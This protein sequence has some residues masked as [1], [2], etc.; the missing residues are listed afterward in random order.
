MCLVSKEIGSEFSYQENNFGHGILLP[1]G[2][3]DYVY[4]FSGRTAIETVLKNEPQ[5]KKAMLPSYCCDSMIEPFRRKGIKVCFYDVNYKDRLQINIKLEDDIDAILWCNYFGFNV[6][7][8]D[9][10]EFL[11]NGGIIIEDITHSFY[12]SK[13]YDKQSNYLVASIR[14]WEPVLCGGYCASIKTNLKYKP[15]NFPSKEFLEDKKKAMNLKREYLEGNTLIEKREFLEK[16]SKSNKWLADNY[17]ELLMDEE[18]KYI[19]KHID[20]KGNIIQRK[21]NAKELFKGLKKCRCVIPL[22]KEEE[23]DCP[24]FVPILAK[25]ENRSYIRKR[26]TENNIYCPIHWPKPNEKCESNL[27][28]MELSLVCDQRYNENDMKRIIEIIQECE[29]NL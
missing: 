29:K 17:F 25:I 16:F 26:L 7:M 9:F 1:E 18:S 24:L 15:L 3:K 13:K 6:E 23:I 27:Y 19:L 11:I 10:S 12:S 14:K 2:V 20:F 28:D 22:F 4:T 8:P 21:N 5:I